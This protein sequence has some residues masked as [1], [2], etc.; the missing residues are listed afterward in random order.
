[1]EIYLIRHTSPQVEKGICY[2]Q[3]DV[4]LAAT[5]ENERKELLNGLPDQLDAVYSSPL[6]RCCQLADYVQAKLPVI[7]DKRLLEMHFG[8]WELKKWDAVEQV[9]LTAWMNDFV[10]VGVPNGENFIDLNNRVHDFII[11]LIKTKHQKIA[12]VTHAGVI[13]CFAAYI[14]ELP[15]KQAFRIQVA[16]ASISKIHLQDERCMNSIEYLNHVQ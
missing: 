2:G 10:N 14:L 16:Y 5:F 1:M 6:S 13:R 12:I 7:T 9:A 4:P 11:D 3:S 15:L 8:D